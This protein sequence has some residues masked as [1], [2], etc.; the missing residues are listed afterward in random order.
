MKLIRK[1]GVASPRTP[2]DGLEKRVQPVQWGVAI[3]IEYARIVVGQTGCEAS[4]PQRINA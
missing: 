4:E 1:L 2:V 3:E